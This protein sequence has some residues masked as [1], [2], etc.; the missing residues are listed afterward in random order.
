[1]ILIIGY[2]NPLRS[3]D[4]VGQVA[5]GIL[6]DGWRARAVV[7]GYV[8]IPTVTALCLHQLTPDLAQPIGEAQMVIFIDAAEDSPAGMIRAECLTADDGQG[9]LTHQCTPGG[10]LWLAR[11]LYEKSPCGWLFSVG[12]ADFDYGENLSWQVE[13][14]LPDLIA[15]IDRLIAAQQSRAHVAQEADR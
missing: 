11:V 15:Q 6:A 12:G 7:S 5:A 9:A 1:M 3:D 2:G 8:S 14:R 13:A 4:G 10:L